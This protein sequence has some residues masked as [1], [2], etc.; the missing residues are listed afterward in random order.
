MAL[1]DVNLED[2]GGGDSAM[3]PARL[4]LQFS[5]RAHK[6]MHD[7]AARLPARRLAVT[8]HHLGDVLIFDGRS[9]VRR[10]SVQWQRSGVVK[11]GGVYIWS[12]VL[13]DFTKW[14]E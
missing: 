3:R 10:D 1:E 9:L 12:G 13:D 8:V 6:H 14:C 5:R 11:L 4:C 7:S 2:A